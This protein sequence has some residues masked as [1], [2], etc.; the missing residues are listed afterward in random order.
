MTRDVRHM[1]MLSRGCLLDKLVIDIEAIGVAT[2]SRHLKL[3]L[4]LRV[5][6]LVLLI[7][8]W[9]RLVN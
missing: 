4:K 7:Y 5:L 6:L 1:H 8:R 2:E 9:V 3:A